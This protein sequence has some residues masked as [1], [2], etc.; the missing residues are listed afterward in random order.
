MVDRNTC[1]TKNDGFRH[2]EER[3]WS[4]DP[5]CK[6]EFKS[7]FVDGSPCGSPRCTC[8]DDPHWQPDILKARVFLLNLFGFEYLNALEQNIMGALWQA[9]VG[10]SVVQ[11]DFLEIT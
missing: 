4:T 9:P 3:S 1:G 10:T 7:A 5:R 8:Y 2:N 11:L 6:S